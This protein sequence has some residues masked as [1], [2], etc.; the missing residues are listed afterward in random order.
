VSPQ[1]LCCSAGGLQD[2]EK[3]QNPAPW[4]FPQQVVYFQTGRPTAGASS[5]YL[6]D[7]K[8]IMALLMV[9]IL[10]LPVYSA[11]EWRIREGGR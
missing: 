8:R 1:S 4:P 3:R 7:E 11:L 6:Q 2:A 10:R 9:M 5:T